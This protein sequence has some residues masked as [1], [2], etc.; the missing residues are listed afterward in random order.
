MNS[1]SGNILKI[2]CPD[3]FANQL[4]LSLAANLLVEKKMA[5]EAVQEWVLNNHN[6][7]DFLKFFHPLPNVRFSKLMD[8]EDLI[9]TQSFEYMTR[10]LDVTSIVDLFN[11]AYGHLRLKNDYKVIIQ[12]FIDKFEIG[13][14]IG[15]HLRTGCKTA[16]LFSEN[17]KG[18]SR[19][20]PHG[21][22]IKFLTTNDKKI[23][24][25]TDNA[26]TQDK[27][28]NVFKERIVFFE[29]IKEGKEKF[30]GT[31]DEKKVVRFA[32]DMHTIA[33]FYILQNCRYFIGSNES[34]FSLMINYIRNN[35]SDYKIDGV[36]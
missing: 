17:G 2:K 3:G 6:I 26:E 28:F 25:A 7:V 22:I 31:Y 36:L 32:G 34:S 12:S 33:D 29:K 23:F 1:K 24:L 19:P 5:D 14:C 35:E 4:R 13:N 9:A 16:L 30:E 8:E 18:R 11:E 10:Q 15:L 20:I 21:A 27:F